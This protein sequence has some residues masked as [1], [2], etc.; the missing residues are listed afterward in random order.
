MFV[1]YA[2]IYG[3]ALV[4]AL[5]AIG[6]N[7]WT[8][9]LPIGLMLAFNTLGKLVA[10]MGFAGG[11]VISLARSAVLSV[12]TYFVAQIV[13]KNRVGVADLRTS[14]GAY[15]WTWIDVF[16]AIWIIS[17]LLGPMMLT[18]ESRQLRDA[19]VMLSLVVF[20]AA[21]EVIYIKGTSGFIETAQRSFSFLQENWIEWFIPNALILGVIWLMIDGTI[22]LR[23]LPMPAVTV[24]VLLGGLLHVVVVFRGFLFEALDGS[25]HRQRMFRFRNGQ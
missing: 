5:A 4:N 8:L 23:A 19:L 16:F 13:A 17:L 21:P 24:P 1:V 2:R 15:F 25:T 6:R 9:V 7:L 20:N 12:Y 3:Q 10:P 11:F 22:P 14:I 18:A